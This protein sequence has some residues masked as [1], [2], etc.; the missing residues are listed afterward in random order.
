MKTLQHFFLLLF[1]YAAAL[2]APAIA[3]PLTFQRVDNGLPTNVQAL[4]ANETSFFAAV[5]GYGIYRSL[6][7]GA[8]WQESWRNEEFQLQSLIATSFGALAVGY[9][10]DFLQ[11]L[12]YRFDG[13]DWTQITSFT[14]IGTTVKSVIER[15]STLYIATEEGFG[16][17]TDRGIS[18]EKCDLPEQAILSTLVETSAGLW[19]A[20][21]TNGIYTQPNGTGVNTPVWSKAASNGLPSDA[22][23]IGL[24]AI[25][26]DLVALTSN[27]A[28]YRSGMSG[29]SWQAMTTGLPNGA[30]VRSLSASGAVLLA[31]VQTDNTVNVYQ[32]SDG[33]WRTSALPDVSTVAVLAA[34]SRTMCCA[35]PALGV[36]RAASGSTQWQ[37]STT[38]LPKNVGIVAFASSSSAAAAT[39]SG[40][41]LYLSAHNGKVYRSLDN[42]LSWQAASDGLSASHPVVSLLQTPSSSGIIAGTSTGRVYRLPENSSEWQAITTFPATAGSVDVLYAAA[43]STL[44]AGVSPKEGSSSEATASG[45]FISNDNGTTW[46]QTLSQTGSVVGA[47]MFGSALF[48]ATNGKGILRSTDG[49]MNWQDFNKGLVALPETYGL[50]SIGTVGD[51]L[52]VGMEHSALG[53]KATYRSTQAALEWE[54]ANNIATG[55]L[56]SA[57]VGL[58][59]HSFAA[60]PEGTIYRVV[61]NEWQDA[62]SC[63]NIQALALHDGNVFAGTNAGLFR[64][65]AT[66]VLTS[67]RANDL[68]HTSSCLLSPNPCPQGGSVKVRFVQKK[69]S[70]S[71]HITLRFIDMLGN[72]VAR[73]PQG[74]MPNGEHNL[75]ISLPQ[76]LARGLYLVSVDADAVSICT[77]RLVVG[78]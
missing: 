32:F 60:T 31:N 21:G 52:F 70:S 73:I 54:Q 62:G 33:T 20:T 56:V 68:A 49:G 47:T 43:G 6:D 66:S 34:N 4:A 13:R 67:V 27:G 29:A 75:R 39:S 28:V 5:P 3:Q 53:F 65:S 24:E 55:K 19:I 77:A 1:L 11:M 57:A 8:S 25:A 64:A 74:I 72:T 23:I 45:V 76:T 44:L 16:C 42:G 41:K 9:D 36:F 2:T 30:L 26:N 78:E 40:A 15:R 46:R 71:A 63:Q 10:K 7:N 50:Q 58:E 14:S 17:S 37:G 51:A 38:G 35:L 61:G 12:V 69:P 59:T 18:W 48:V 22:T